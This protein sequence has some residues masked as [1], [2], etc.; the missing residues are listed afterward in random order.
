M[1]YAVLSGLTEPVNSARGV[2]RT[3]AVATVLGTVAVTLPAL[4]VATW[5]AARLREECARLRPE[6]VEASSIFGPEDN[7]ILGEALMDLHYT[8]SPSSR[9]RVRAVCF[10][11]ASG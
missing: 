8:L 11:N 1:W 6:G 7:S 10:G 9:A 5:G 2:L 4:A 3:V